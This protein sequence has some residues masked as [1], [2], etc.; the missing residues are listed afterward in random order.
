MTAA[1]TLN[2]FERN[3]GSGYVIVASRGEN[4]ILFSEK[5][6]RSAP[7]ARATKLLFWTSTVGG[8]ILEI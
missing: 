6:I 1:G 7:T 4:R 8:G 2:I 3:P 5:A